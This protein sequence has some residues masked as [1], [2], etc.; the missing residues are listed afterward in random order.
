MSHIIGLLLSYEDATVGRVYSFNTLQEQ[1]N[2]QPGIE[3]AP[4]SF[5]DA[6]NALP[7]DRPPEYSEIAVTSY[8][9]E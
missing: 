3:D 7:H 2:L 9:F 6:L 5:D 1:Q 4:P 8:V